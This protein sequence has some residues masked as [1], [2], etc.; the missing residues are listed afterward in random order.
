ML[1]PEHNDVNER[2]GRVETSIDSLRSDFSELRMT[3]RTIQ[4]AIS[5][6]RETNWGTVFAGLAI[7]GAIYAAA[8]RPLSADIMRQERNAETL[9]HAVI[10]KEEKIADLQRRMAIIEYIEQGKKP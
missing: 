1:P 2:L 5:R 8:I 3:L 6:G 7:V 9:A 10:V 4:E